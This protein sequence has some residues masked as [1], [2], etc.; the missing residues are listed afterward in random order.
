MPVARPLSPLTTVVR[1]LL[2]ARRHQLLA[3]LEHL[4]QDFREDLSNA[5]CQ[6]TR[7]RIRHELIPF[8]ETHFN[9]S[10]S[11][12]LVRLGRHA[13]QVQQVVDHLVD[14]LLQQHVRQQRDRVTIDCPPLAQ[15]PRHILCELLIAV[16]KRQDWSLQA[17][18][19][20]KWEQVAS[21]LCNASP[22][23]LKICLPGNVVVQRVDDQLLVSR[24]AASAAP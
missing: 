16:W 12:A 19:G 8:L 7:N 13:S 10:A 20:Q 24:Q 14:E 15:Q 1:P 9:P 4:G 11:E 2:A 3:Y 5:E 21:L 23:S 22:A 18:G 17:M 6:F